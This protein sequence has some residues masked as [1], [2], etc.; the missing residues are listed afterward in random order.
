S[1]T[2]DE[3][4][5]DQFGRITGWV[6]ILPPL[7]PPSSKSEIS[8]KLYEL[9]HI[10]QENSIITAS[11]LIA[12]TLQRFRNRDN[13]DFEWQEL[14]DQYNAAVTAAVESRFPFDVRL[15]EQAFRD[16]QLGRFMR[17]KGKKWLLKKKRQYSFKEEELAQFASS[18]RTVDDLIW[19]ANNIRHLKLPK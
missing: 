13:S 16:K 9:K 3:L 14:K 19:N 6:K 8:N 1:L 5:Q 10:L 7:E 2:Y 11:H 12:A 18:E 15:K 4:C 17:R